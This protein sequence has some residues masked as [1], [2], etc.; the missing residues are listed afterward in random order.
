MLV[1]LLPKLILNKVWRK[2]WPGML[3]VSISFFYT[4]IDEDHFKSAHWKAQ[5]YGQDEVVIW[6]RQQILTSCRFHIC[7]FASS[8]K[9]ICDKIGAQCEITAIHGNPQSWQTLLLPTEVEQ[10][11]PLLSCFKSQIVNKCPFYDLSALLFFSF[12]AF[13]LVISPFKMAPSI[14]LKCCPGTLSTRRLG[15][16][17]Q[18][19]L[20][21]A[22]LPRIQHLHFPLSLTRWNCRCPSKSKTC[23]RRKWVH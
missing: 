6:K 19:W 21:L 11:N 9:L 14:V 15:A 22:S 13:L 8:L 23:L 4:D 18:F 12:C 16:V 10:D 7:E 20:A 1:L 17:I 3:S 5:T 2:S